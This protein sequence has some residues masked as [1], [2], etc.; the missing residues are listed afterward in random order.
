MYH[1]NKFWKCSQECHSRWATFTHDQK[2]LQQKEYLE[3]F[4][5]Q[6]FGGYHLIIITEW[7]R[8]PGYA[9]SLENLFNKT[10]INQFAGMMCRERTVKANEANPLIISEDD[11]KVLQER[12]VVDT[13]LYN[14]YTSC[15]EKGPQ[16]W[17]RKINFV[18]HEAGFGYNSMAA[19]AGTHGNL[20]QAQEDAEQEGGGSSGGDH[21]EGAPQDE[22]EE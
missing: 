1:R 2:I 4:A 20:T 21:E 10:G 16:F 9:A 5:R 14:E 19:A 3:Q 8:M 6:V 11:M 22:V 12:N 13:K 7:L 15:P 18:K 17:N